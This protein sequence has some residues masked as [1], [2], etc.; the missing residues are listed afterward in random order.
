MKRIKKKILMGERLSKE[1]G[2][3]LLKSNN[4]LS[5]GRLADAEKQKRTKDNVFFNINCHVNITNICVARCSFC[6]F[7]RDKGE[8]AA[9]EMSLEDIISK[10]RASLNTGIT[11]VHIVSGL[12]PDQPFDF[13]VNVL[14]EI[15][16]E[17]PSIHIKA[18]TPVEIKYF[19]NISGLSIKDVFLRLK[20]AG[21]GSMPGGGAEVLSSRVRQELCP[22]KATAD[23]WL[24][25]MET[26]HLMGLKTNATLLFG[27]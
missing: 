10:I 8:S 23:D 9:Y 25:I 21:L 12:H 11:E 20:E 2:L 5:M 26:A 24:K 1:D 16:G 7:S 19:S 14:R 13:Y 27:H 22:E 18:F 17:F 3:F 6:A 15:S 4:L